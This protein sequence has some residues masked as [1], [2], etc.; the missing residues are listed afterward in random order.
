MRFFK[1]IF[2]ALVGTG[3]RGEAGPDAGNP[4]SGLAESNSG[5]SKARGVKGR[6]VG[7]E[8]G[9][10]L[11]SGA[12]VPKGTMERRMDASSGRLA[13]S[14]PQVKRGG[15]RWWQVWR[16]GQPAARSPQ[17]LEMLFSSVHPVRN[18]LDDEPGNT[19]RVKSRLIFETKPDAAVTLRRMQEESDRTWVRLRGRRLKQLEVKSE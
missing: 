7:K 17:Q 18:T 13:V 8:A 9:K 4:F 15:R 16:R 1:R 5:R 3:G 2:A 11:S 12:T 14:G 10:G 6:V 19:E